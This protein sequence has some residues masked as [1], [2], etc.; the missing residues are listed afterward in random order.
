MPL[1]RGTEPLSL[2]RLRGDN[3]ECGYHGLQFDPDGQ[4]VRI[5][6]QKSIP[7]AAKVRSYPV[8][9]SLGFVWIWLGDPDLADPQSCFR[10]AALAEPKR[11]LSVG[12]HR[13]VKCH[14]QLLTDNLTDP[15]HVTFVHRSTLGSAAQEDIPV[16][17]Q[18]L[19]D[20][21]IV[22]R[23]TLDSPPAPI[24]E[25]LAGMRGHVDRWQYYY[26]YCP[27]I[28]VVDFGSAP[29][30]RLQHDSPREHHPAV[31]IYSCIFLTPETERSTHY[32]YVQS[33][34]FALGDEALS[35]DVVAQ[36]AVAFD[37]D[38]VILEAQQ[39]SSAA[40]QHGQLCRDRR[41]EVSVGLGA[42]AATAHRRTDA[43]QRALWTLNVQ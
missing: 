22:S 29:A 17:V 37:E 41:C 1:A 16:E 20:T 8:H 7:A 32:F 2:G 4:C 15:A 25:N 39:R 11:T 30:G 34:H 13:L 24:F 43:L 9:E 31:Q 12:A 38:F 18:E 14:Y 19:D 26:L 28:C 27:A 6:G 10:L 5:Q 33:R 21:V 42:Y 3:L 23:W 35:R 40:A 36:L